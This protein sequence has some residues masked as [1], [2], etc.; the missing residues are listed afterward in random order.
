MRATLNGSVSSALFSTSLFRKCGL[1]ANATATRWVALGVE[2]SSS[3]LVTV[4]VAEDVALPSSSKKS[5]SGRSSS[6]SPCMI[7]VAVTAVAVSQ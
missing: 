6:I 4:V 7:V 3:T 1:S 2:R 5:S